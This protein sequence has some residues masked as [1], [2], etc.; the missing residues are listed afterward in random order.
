[1]LEAKDQEHK[2]NY[3][4]KKGL[5]KIFSRPAAKQKIFKKFFQAISKKKKKSMGVFKVRRIVLD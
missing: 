2:R 4:Q 5:Q 3:F 1:M